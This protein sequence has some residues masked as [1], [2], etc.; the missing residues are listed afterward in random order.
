MSEPRTGVR[1]VPDGMRVTRRGKLKKLRKRSLLWRWRR[2]FYLALLLVV[3]G[4]AGAFWVLSQVELPAA[5]DQLRQTTFVCFAQTTEGC[6]PENA[7]FKLKGDEDRVN[8]T[9][10]D[11]PDVVVE[12]VISAEDRDFFQHGGIDPVGIARA[13]M[14]NANEEEITQGGSTIT[15]QYVK[16]VYLT[17]ERSIT[18][19]LREA[20]LAVR[21]DDELSKEEILERYLNTIYFGRGAY[22]IQAAARNYF[23]HDIQEL[24]GLDNT[25]G[26]FSPVEL[27]QVAYLAGLIRAPESA[28][29]QRNPNVATQRRDSVLAAM[30]DEGYITQDE[31][32]AAVAEGWEVD[33]LFAS[34]N[35]VSRSPATTLG[36]V[37]DHEHGTEY[38]AEYVRQQLVEQFGEDQV[39]GGGLRVYTTLSLPI[40]QAA[41]DTV[42][43]TLDLPG[44]PAASI[45]ALDDRGR[46]RAMMGGT[47]FANQSVNLAVGV[48]GGGSGRQPGSS[49]KPFAVATALK[50]GYSAQAR[51]T[52]PS[53]GAFNL[54][55]YNAG[56]GTWEVSGGGGSHSVMTALPAS[57]NMFF[58]TLMLKLGSASVIETAHQMGVT[59]DLPEVPSI[60]LGAGEVSPL[61]MASAYSTFMNHGT[62]YEPQVISR[63]EDA[64]GNVIWEAPETGQQVLTPEVADITT[65]AMRSVVTSGTGTAASLGDIAAAGKTGT[66]QNNKDAWF[67]GFRC[68]FVASVWMGYPGFNGEPV[69]PMT[70]VHGERQEGGRFPARMWHDFMTTV[71]PLL[72]DNCDLASVS[73]FP[74]GKDYD[75][76]GDLPG[77]AIPGTVDTTPDVPVSVTAPP[78]TSPPVTTPPT[79]AP[80]VT[81]PPTPTTSPGG[82]RNGGGEAADGPP[83]GTRQP[84]PGP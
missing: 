65:T 60:V 76:D 4:A 34:R 71:D 69:V 18:R 25:T 59:A 78:V 5:N 41:Y 36:V 80:P 58:A 24:D 73:D 56:G 68:N 28:D 43:G 38:F 55:D 21:L 7:D 72:N 1:D 26:Q 10:E 30:L 17:R 75:D 67:V 35:I 79:T 42:T 84:G 23:R 22:G 83:G 16:N 20:I 44:D 40:Q 50:E 53:S 66:T 64:D 47:D 3:G 15:Q 51:M 70:N 46:V 8:I 31:H 37:R 62:H 49:F 29:A 61:D 52:V 13:V 63:V 19:K 11:L 39:Y 9:Y 14:A 54:A 82:V 6:G 12:A 45:V 81:T 57:S 27:A 32:D 33:D 74:D 48:E 77:S 2:V